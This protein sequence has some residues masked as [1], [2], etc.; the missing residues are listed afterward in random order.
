MMKRSLDLAAEMGVDLRGVLTWAFTFPGSP[1]FAGYRA[2]ATNGIHLPVLNAFK[3]LGSLHG[4]RLPLASDGAMSLADLLQN[5]V[6]GEPDVDA[7]AA[8]DGDRVQI[9]VWNYHDDIVEAEPAEVLLDVA[10]P[11]AFRDGA[12]VTHTRVDETHGD[13]FSVWISQ[14]R[15]ANPT[16]D[17][18]SAL[19]NGMEP[20]VLERDR[21]VEV[22]NGVV[23]LS[24]ELP[25]FG[26]ALVTLAPVLGKNAGAAQT[27]DADGS[28]RF[29]GKKTTSP[30]ALIPLLLALAIGC[31]RSGPR[32]WQFGSRARVIVS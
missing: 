9:L 2:L 27:S 6:R 25:R 4:N 11:P 12:L 18:E 8:I 31:R 7:L 15:P 13:A 29:G 23:N 17:Q 20:V 28:C 22:T 10:L 24:F 19:R 21:A 32:Y 1:Y 3:L 30:S 14:G 5:G 26:I 16:A